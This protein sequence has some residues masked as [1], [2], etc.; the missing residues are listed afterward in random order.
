MRIRTA[1]ELGAFIRE[2]RVKLDLDQLALAKKAGTSRKWLIEVERGKPSAEMG[3]V[4]RTLKA[5]D[6]R[7]ELR[8]D[9]EASPPR[10]EDREHIDINQVLSALKKQP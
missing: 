2:R 10:H 9:V 6:V 5:L 1:S 3:L 8:V 7:I 4:L